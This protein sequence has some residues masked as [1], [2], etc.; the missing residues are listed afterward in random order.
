VEPV[1]TPTVYKEFLHFLV[2]T[3][4]KRERVANRAS[5]GE[6]YGRVPDWR[7]LYKLDPTILRRSYSEF[8]TIRR[9]LI[10]SRCAVVAPDEIPSSPSVLGYDEELIANICRYRLDSSDASILLEATRLG[11]PD[12]V[13]LDKDLL[14]AG[15]FH[16]LHVAVGS[17]RR[18]PFGEDLD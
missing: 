1:V 16:D 14:R 5:L 15:R 6:R 9:G 12:I 18:E 7:E 10:A 4:F 8:E 11:I 13:T 2:A 17:P 3:T